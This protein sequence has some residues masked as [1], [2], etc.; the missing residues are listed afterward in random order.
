M[1]LFVPVGLPSKRNLL[2]R[3]E[4][5]SIEACSG[6]VAVKVDNAAAD[7]EDEK[8]DMGN[9]ENKKSLVTYI[10]KRNAQKARYSGSDTSRICSNH[11]TDVKETNFL[12]RTLLST[13]PYGFISTL[14]TTTVCATSCLYN[15]RGFA[16]CELNGATSKKNVLLEFVKFSP[17]CSRRDNHISS[18]FAFHIHVYSHTSC[19]T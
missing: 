3:L 10:F 19:D 5:F 7:R 9:Q 11:E 18:S 1:H 13:S 17:I 14:L 2:S 15:V 8:F 4:L 12:C 16:F 6:S